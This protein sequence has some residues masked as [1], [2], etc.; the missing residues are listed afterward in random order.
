MECPSEIGCACVL[1]FMNHYIGAQSESG[2]AGS[3][4][5]YSG[6][7][8]CET[9]LLR[10]ICSRRI[11]QGSEL[12][13][14][15]SMTHWVFFVQQYNDGG[16]TYLDEL[17][18]FVEG[19]MLDVS[20]IGAVAGL[21]VLDADPATPQ[22]HSNQRF[23]QNFFKTLMALSEGVS[24]SMA[25]P[26]SKPAKRTTSPSKRMTPVRTPPPTH[27]ST[28]NPPSNSPTTAANLVSIWNPTHMTIDKPVSHTSPPTLNTRDGGTE[29]SLL[30]YLSGSSPPTMNSNNVMTAGNSQLPLSSEDSSPTMS[31]SDVS[32]ADEN[33]Q[34]ADLISNGSSPSLMSST[35]AA[36][37]SELSVLNPQA[38][39][40]DSPSPSPTTQRHEESGNML[41]YRGY[42]SSRSEG[43]R[44]KVCDCKRIITIFITFYLFIF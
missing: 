33:A 15:T 35:A 16:W 23:T 28:T 43:T 18:E 30:Q 13:W 6:V 17:H 36:E 42:M 9:N 5:K 20:F 12:R 41:W 26:E 21:S 44:N 22:D 37:N 39:T 38:T 1:G 19:N 25:K 29:D 40:A 27:R 10:S 31:S 11:N 2:S 14:I 34:H 8:F 7:D 32:M 3:H 4:E 24:Q